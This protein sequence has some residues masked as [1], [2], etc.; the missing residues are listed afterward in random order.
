MKNLNITGIFTHLSSADSLEEKDV[1]FT[2][3]Q[4]N[5]F[6]NLLDKLKAGGV[7]I[8]KI[9]IQSSYGL[10]NYPELECDYVRMGIALYGVLSSPGDMTKLQLDLKPVLS[11]KARVILIREVK[12]GESVGYGRAFTATRDSLIG[13]LP[14][15]YADGVPRSLSCG[16]SYVLINGQY[17]PV[18]GRICMDQLAVDVT[19]IR[20][21]N[22]DS[23]ATL[24]GKDG[25]EEITAQAAAGSADSITNE[26]LS[27]M[28]RRLVI[29]R[30]K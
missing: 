6:Y 27:R 12:Q 17:A 4:I 30:K 14:V 1:E 21:I 7:N 3:K 18:V 16:N 9:H 20:G 19:D 29:V 15:G 13:I 10:L 8:P 24:I 25:N 28:G 5:S 23:V 11:L 22:I 2:R 26:L